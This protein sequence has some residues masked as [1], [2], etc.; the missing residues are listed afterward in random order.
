[1]LF[2]SHKLALGVA[3]A[4]LIYSKKLSPQIHPFL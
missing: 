2:K 4:S 1:M 3:F